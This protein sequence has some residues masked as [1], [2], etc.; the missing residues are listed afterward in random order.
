MPFNYSKLDGLITEKFKTRA[1]FAKAIGLSERSLS[2]KMSG[3]NYWT[4]PQIKQ[5]CEVLGIP[6][7]DIPIYFFVL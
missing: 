4:Q 2:L 1:A 7:K 6:E 3:K 5:C